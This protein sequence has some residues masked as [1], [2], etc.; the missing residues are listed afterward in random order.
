MSWDI[1]LYIDKDQIEVD[2]VT[3]N[4]MQGTIMG[5]KAKS[6]STIFNHDFRG[7]RRIVSFAGKIGLLG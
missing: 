4:Q 6:S 5:I 7:L 3:E 2:F 1:F